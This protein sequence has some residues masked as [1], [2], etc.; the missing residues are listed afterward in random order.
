MARFSARSAGPAAR[1]SV[2]GFVQPLKYKKHLIAQDGT[3]GAGALKKGADGNDV[4][5]E[6]PLGTVVKDAE[7]GIVLFG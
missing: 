1:C 7:T 5:I 3:P 2:L 4:I 6:V